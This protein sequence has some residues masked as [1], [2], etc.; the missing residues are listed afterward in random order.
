MTPMKNIVT[1][2]DIYIYARWVDAYA[3]TA[4]EINRWNIFQCFVCMEKFIETNIVK[5]QKSPSNT[6]TF[7]GLTYVFATYHRIISTK[8]SKRKVPVYFHMS[9]IIAFIS[10]LKCTNLC[11]LVSS[12]VSSSFGLSEFFYKCHIKRKT[13]CLSINVTLIA[14]WLLNWFCL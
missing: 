13:L 10:T 14:S 7:N 11:S 5:L 12:C 9:L 1:C 2:Y 6:S 4:Q 3:F 8:F